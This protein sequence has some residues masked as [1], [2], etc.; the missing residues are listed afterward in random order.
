MASILNL[1]SVN[2]IDSSYE[3]VLDFNSLTSQVSFFNSKT[4]KLLSFDFQG[5]A[6][7][8]SLTIPATLGEVIRADYCFF[9]G[10]DN[11]YYYYFINSKEFKTQDV[12]LLG[13]TLDVYSTYL[14]DF[15]F[16][17]SFVD[18]CHV[19]RFTSSG[20]PT[21]EVV[22]EG[23]TNSNYV[24][25]SKTEICEYGYH[26]IMTALEPLGY[27][28]QHNG[29][30]GGGTTNGLI[31]KKG[32]RFIKGYEAFTPSGLYLNGEH[33]R[34]VGYGSTESA[35]KAYYDMHKPFPCTEMLASEIFATRIMN[36]FGNRIFA[37]CEEAGIHTQITQSMFDAMCS[38]AYNTGLGS[39]SNKNGFLHAPTSPWQS[40]KLDPTNFNTIR[41][42]WESFAVT[43]ASTGETLSGL[44]KRRKAEA[45]VY[46]KGEY[47][48]R[49][50]GIY[51][52]NGNGVGVLS[53]TVTDNDGSGYIPANL[54]DLGIGEGQIT[55]GD[56]NTWLLPTKGEITAGYP[57]YDSGKFHGG[58]DFANKQGTPIYATGSGTI[59]AIDTYAGDKEA[60]PYG[61]LVIINQTGNKTGNMYKVYYAHLD[62]IANLKAGDTVTAGQ[63]IGTMGTTGNSTGN[64]LHYEI[65]KTPYSPQSS[66][67]INPAT[68]LSVGM[69]I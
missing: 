16:L 32:F 21:F 62:T 29:T 40:I 63:Q 68:N 28:Q 14:F 12:T 11:K 58:I 57:N 42:V 54:P 50:I 23:F 33:F 10:D 35:N 61:N 25:V 2:E 44:V 41:K 15:E 7:R 37:A 53:G 22:D 39:A 18:R 59:A 47:E 64:H 51:K 17:H 27:M 45:D 56:G 20:L 67:A 48:I 3:H 46:C 55:D 9:Q 30:G 13:L 19:D 66:T 1:C 52:D 69:T 65:R 60:Q 6:F 5:D 31:T 4:I 38:L 34:T 24:Q 8:T 49:S 26:Y 36:E 43:S